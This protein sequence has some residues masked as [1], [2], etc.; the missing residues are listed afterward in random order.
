MRP[1]S[2]VSMFILMGLLSLAACGGGGGSDGSSVSQNQQ[3]T[4]PA[5][6]TLYTNFSLPELLT[7]STS[8][9]PFGVVQSSGTNSSQILYTAQKYNQS[10]QTYTAYSLRVD[11]SFSIPASSLQASNVSG[12]TGTVSGFSQTIGNVTVVSVTGL[13]LDASTFTNLNAAGDWRG[14]WRLVGNNSS[15][16]QGVS[17]ALGSVSIFCGANQTGVAVGLMTQSSTSLVSFLTT[18]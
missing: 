1:N 6:L 16:I 9:S 8:S 7:S 13:R 10:T 3:P 14:L 2:S 4:A 17:G 11:G 5:T 18:C 15:G 12:T